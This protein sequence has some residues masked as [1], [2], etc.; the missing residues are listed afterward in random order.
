MVKTPTQ[1]IEESVE[2]SQKIPE[3]DK[4]T[5]S[6]APEIKIALKRLKNESRRTEIKF[7]KLVDSKDN[8]LLISET[9][10]LGSNAGIL[11]TELYDIL[12]AYEGS[13]EI[14]C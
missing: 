10:F 1:A 11:S 12:E 3:I 13:G 14:D 8:Y 2:I 9:C 5:K 4:I 7:S 6:S